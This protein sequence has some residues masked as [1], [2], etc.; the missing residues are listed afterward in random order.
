MLGAFTEL[1]W[2]AWRSDAP[3]LVALAGGGGGRWGAVVC[4]WCAWLLARG[5]AQTQR[6]T[7]AAIA[8]V[9]EV[10]CLVLSITN[11]PWRLGKPHLL[12]T[13]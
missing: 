13:C 5:L 7:A 12:G 8:V 4:W 11:S 9:C 1:P 3:M 10:V 2:A 6:G